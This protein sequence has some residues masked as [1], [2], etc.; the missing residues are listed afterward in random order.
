MEKYISAIILFAIILTALSGCRKQGTESV[1][2]ADLTVGDHGNVL[3][4]EGQHPA[5]RDHG[6]VR[7]L[8]P[9]GF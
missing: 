1:S 4:Q 2:G 6:W 5:R 9:S 3:C 8:N 7:V